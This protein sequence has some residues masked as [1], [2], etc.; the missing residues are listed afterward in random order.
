MR[1]EYRREK[2]RASWDGKNDEREDLM[3][4]G[5]EDE[6][7]EGMTKVVIV[8][9]RWAEKI[10][11]TE[12]ENMHVRAWR[13]G[14][15]R[16]CLWRKGNRE[17]CEWKGNKEKCVKRESGEWTW[18]MRFYLGEERRYFDAQKFISSVSHNIIISEFSVFQK[19]TYSLSSTLCSVFVWIDMNSRHALIVDIRFE[20]NVITW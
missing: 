3:Y 13:K 15:E 12:S 5:R 16:G 19:M 2:I 18:L 8:W 11:W 1:K 10:E 6:G 17:E 7:Q 14:D 9:G 4:D 20:F